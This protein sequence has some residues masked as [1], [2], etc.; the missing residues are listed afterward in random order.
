MVVKVLPSPYS[1]SLVIV[2]L[3]RGR[4]DLHIA[5]AVDQITDANTSYSSVDLLLRATFTQNSDWE[6]L[7]VTQEAYRQ[8]VAQ[9]LVS[10]GWNVVSLPFQHFAISTF[11]HC[12][13]CNAAMGR[14]MLHLVCAYRR[15]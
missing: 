11:S 3:C 15:L 6:D 9:N 8:Q 1:S 4:P 2:G 14:L 13:Q 7:G 12:K 5:P 10:S